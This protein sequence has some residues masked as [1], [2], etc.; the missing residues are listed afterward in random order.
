MN[1][2]AVAMYTGAAAHLRHSYVLCTGG[3]V[4][5]AYVR[6]WQRVSGREPAEPQHP[7]NFTTPLLAL[8]NRDKNCS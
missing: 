3:H 2:T 6:A 8:H 7:G 5:R 1:A 4:L